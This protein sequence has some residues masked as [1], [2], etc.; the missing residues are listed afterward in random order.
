MT[1]QDFVTEILAAEEQAAQDV[2]KAHKKAQNDLS[3]YESK[4]SKDR[5][6]NLNTLREQSKEKL[7]ERQTSARKNY[8]NAIEDGKREAAQLEKD[9]SPKADKHLSTAQAYF[10]NELL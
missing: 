9:A 2:E 4:L 1:Q 3:Q 7:K 5:E 6:K 10:I 8:E